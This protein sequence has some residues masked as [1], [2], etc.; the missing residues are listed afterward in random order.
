MGTPAYRDHDGE[1]GRT[2]DPGGV[3]R[4]ASSPLRRCGVLSRSGRHTEISAEFGIASPVDFCVARRMHLRTL[5]PFFTRSSNDR[6]DASRK[7]VAE[8]EPLLPYPKPPPRVAM[9]R[10]EPAIASETPAT[11]LLDAASPN[12][13]I[14]AAA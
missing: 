14:Q 12:C 1:H 4:R 5:R 6:P 13:G 10:R 2:S 7:T 11:I 8:R 9:M 3:A